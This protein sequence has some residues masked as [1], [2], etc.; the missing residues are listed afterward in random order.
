MNP[1]AL[2]LSLITCPISFIIVLLWGVGAAIFKLPSASYYQ[3][4]QMWS[5]YCSVLKTGKKAYDGRSKKNCMED[6]TCE[7]YYSYSS[8]FATMF[9]G[10]S[11]DEAHW[12]GIEEDVAL[13]SEGGGGRGG[14]RRRG[15][16]QGPGQGNPIPAGDAASLTTTLAAHHRPSPPP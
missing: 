4:C 13:E 6:A 15:R 14:N 5:H 12:G 2:L 10:D 8:L 1:I 7:V 11:I 16:P 3:E 9:D